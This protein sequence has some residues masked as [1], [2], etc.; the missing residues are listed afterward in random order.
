MRLFSYVLSL[1]AVFAPKLALAA[2]Q[3]SQCDTDCLLKFRQAWTVDSA[4]WVNTNVTKDDFFANPSNLS[5]YKLGDLVK[6]EDITRDDAFQLWTIPAGMSLSRFFYISEDID[7]KPIPATA[8]ALLP[9]HN[10]LGEKPLRTVVWAHGTAG[11]TRQCAPSN[12]KTLYYNWEAPFAIANQGYAVIA[13]DYAGQGSDIPQGFMYESGALHAADVGHGLQAARKALGKAI[14]N[15]WVVIGH[16]GDVVS[17]YLF[18]SIC[19]L[20]PSIRFEDYASDIVAHRIVLADQACLTADSA[21]FGGLTVDELYKNTS[22][23]THPDVVDWQKRYNGVGTH[24]LTAPML[25]IQGENDTLTYTEE[26]EEDFDKTCQ[27]YP[28]SRVEMLLYPGLDHDPLFQASLPD[29]LAWIKARFDGEEAQSGCRK[30]TVKPANS[31][32]SITQLDW[33]A[34]VQLG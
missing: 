11:G 22:W 3:R 19:R 25:V 30:R 20:V 9:Y 23:L 18:Q 14:S 28:E 33:E 34:M 26:L 31:R 17:I 16:I 15:E 21:L 7:G 12:H 32:S 10:P 8:F 27:E 1:A 5:D 24:K 2:P 6:W 4:A 13:P 29:Y